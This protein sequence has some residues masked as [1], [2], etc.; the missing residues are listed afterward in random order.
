MVKRVKR[1]TP[2]VFFCTVR[3]GKKGRLLLLTSKG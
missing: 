3:R 2:F 1:E